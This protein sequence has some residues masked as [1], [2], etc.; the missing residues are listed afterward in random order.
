LPGERV[1]ER[2]ESVDVRAFTGPVEQ[3]VELV[4]DL[5]DAVG[6]VAALRVTSARSSDR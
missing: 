1:Q 4:L 3:V 6:F 5:G 2:D